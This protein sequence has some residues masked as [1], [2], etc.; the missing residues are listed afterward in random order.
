MSATDDP[1]IRRRP[2]GSIDLDHYDHR[3]RPARSSDQRAALQRLIAPVN[4]LLGAGPGMSLSGERGS[5]TAT[6]FVQQS[7]ADSNTSVSRQHLLHRNVMNA[8]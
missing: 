3:P 7:P 6:R 1:I 5:P 4:R 8:R 2:D